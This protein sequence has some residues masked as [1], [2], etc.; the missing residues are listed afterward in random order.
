VDDALKI[1]DAANKHDVIL[2]LLGALAIT[3]HSSE[4]SDVHR[5]LRRLADETRTFTDV[6]L[7]G[8]SKQRVKVREVIEDE[9]GYLV[10]QNVLLFRGK[11][12]LL[13]HH[14]QGLYNID[15]FFDYLRFSHDI[16]F[17]PE[18]KKGRLLLDYP[19]ISPTDLLLEKLQ[20]H[21]ISQK[22]LKDI[23]VLFRAHELDVAD[24]PN[25][26]N[27]E[28]VAELLSADWGFWKDATANLRDVISYS[29]KYRSER[30]LTP[31]DFSDVSNKVS[32]V[33]D[34]VEKEAKTLRWKLRDKTGESRQ[35]WNN[36]EE[37]S[38]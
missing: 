1:V 31:S 13:Y 8:Y 32:R 4:F 33:L 20:I 34:A 22:D 38:R 26:I 2:R 10:D 27:V 17:G 9:L 29:E 30:M 23:V 18:P 35:W 11:E 25:T 28:Y 36:V 5:S 12:R 6:D 19:T 3:L 7:I 37:V 14:P 21:S 15:I 24:K 16:L